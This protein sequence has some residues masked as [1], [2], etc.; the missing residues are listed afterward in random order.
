M[1]R[2]NSWQ[3]AKITG[4]VHLDAGD[5]LEVVIPAGRRS[6]TVSEAAGRT[7]SVWDY[8]NNREQLIYGDTGLRNIL[9]LWDIG[10]TGGRATLSRNGNQIELSVYGVASTGTVTAL[11]LPVGFRPKYH[12]TFA[13]AIHGATDPNN[14]VVVTFQGD[15]WQAGTVSGD[16]IY[17]TITYRTEDP[18]PTTFPGVAA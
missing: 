8:L 16:L 9:S 11:N 13:R 2:T 1:K 4:L 5:G 17:F 7:V 18:W 12:R 3:D 6:Y 14:R 10:S 15:V